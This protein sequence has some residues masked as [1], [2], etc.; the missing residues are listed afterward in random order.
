MIDI[1]KLTSLFDDD[2]LVRKYLERFAAHMPT[3]IHQMRDT[4]LQKQWGALSLHAHTFK[5]QLQYVSEPTAASTAYDLER[6]SAGTSPDEARLE[7]L[8]NSLET[9]LGQIM[10]EILAITG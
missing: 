9:Q 6:E 2:M 7:Q 1:Q 10:I 8:I 3:L 5:S 4:F